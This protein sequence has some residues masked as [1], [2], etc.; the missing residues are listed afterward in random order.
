MPAV[1]LLLGMSG[2]D[3]TGGG[4]SSPHNDCVPFEDV[5][6][7]LDHTTIQS[8]SA[9]SELWENSGSC[10]AG[11]R[12]SELTDGSGG[13]AC[14]LDETSQADVV[15]GESDGDGC[16]PICGGGSC[17]DDGCGGSC[18]PC[19]GPSLD[20]PEGIDLGTII[21]GEAK[22]VAF[23]FSNVGTEDLEV[24][25]FVLSGHPSFSFIVGPPYT[26]EVSQWPASPEA[27]SEG[28]TFDSPIVVS[29]GATVT[30]TARFSPQIY[31]PATATLTLFSNDPGAP[32][33]TVIEFRANQEFPCMFINPH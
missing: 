28:I 22:S 26:S 2:C 12:C 3:D 33:G 1:L 19:D 23:E 11:T 27:A 16:V 14:V 13:V 25:R 30:A 32:E 21:E 8:C 7:C 29:P 6:R 17:G 31:V 10:D 15:G 5:Q 9:V 4:S 24:T 20:A 18:G